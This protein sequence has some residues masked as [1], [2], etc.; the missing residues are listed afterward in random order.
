MVQV[1][2]LRWPPRPYIVKTFK[3]RIILKLD[4]QHRGLKVSKDYIND[5][6][7]M[8]MTYFTTRFNLYAYAFEWGKLLQSHLKGK[9]CSK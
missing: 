4:M 3:N 5:D 1:T 8:T 2:W 9:T 6:S 7:G